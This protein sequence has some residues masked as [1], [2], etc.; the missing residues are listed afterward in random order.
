[1]FEELNRNAEFKEPQHL[2]VEL[3]MK[4]LPFAKKTV[5]V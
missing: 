1:M 3:I 4:I 5:D 2:G